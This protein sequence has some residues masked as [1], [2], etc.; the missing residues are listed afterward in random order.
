MV[1]GLIEQVSGGNEVSD[2][3]DF[4]T[5]KEKPN[6]VNDQIKNRSKTMNIE[7]P[8]KKIPAPPLLITTNTSDSQTAFLNSN[9]SPNR[10]PAK[11]TISMN[12]Q[13][14][15][16]PTA[17]NLQPPA[18]NLQMPAPNLLPPPPPPPNLTG[19]YNFIFFFLIMLK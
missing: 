12:I 7:S 8:E 15:I 9:D 13:P 3:M 2:D 10:K 4:K 11:T 5:E 14:K 18:N 6:E 17:S 19:I 16:Q 1:I